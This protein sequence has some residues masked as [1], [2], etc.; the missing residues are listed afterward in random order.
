[1]KS[2]EKIAANAA[3]KAVHSTTRTK[4]SQTWF[5]SQTG[6]IAQSICARARLPRSP[7]PASSDQKPAPKSAPPNTA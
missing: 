2:V 5:D 3:E 6:P 4:I 7:P 1:M